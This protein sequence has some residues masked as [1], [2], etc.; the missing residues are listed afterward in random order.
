MIRALLI[1]DGH[2]GITIQDL[3]RPGYLAHGLSRGGAADRLAIA[4]GAA[5][6]GQ[7]DTKAAIEMAGIGSTFEATEDMRIALTGAPMRAQIDGANIA[8][9][10]SHIL[11]KGA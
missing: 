11:P 4:E 6:L 8:W 7:L 2:P 5:L 3:G 10:A 9:N 1:H